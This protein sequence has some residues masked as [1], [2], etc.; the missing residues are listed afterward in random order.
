MDAYYVLCEVEI[1]FFIVLFVNIPISD[2]L[3]K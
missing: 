1:K 3:D 2:L